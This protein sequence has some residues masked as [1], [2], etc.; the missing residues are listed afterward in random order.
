MLR[1]LLWWLPR[2]GLENNI[3][4]QEKNLGWLKPEVLYGFAYPRNEYAK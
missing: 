3:F 1:S 2:N 4:L